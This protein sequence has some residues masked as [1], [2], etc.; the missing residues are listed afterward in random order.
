MTTH[1][2]HLALD[3][4]H[5]LA[6]DVYP[7]L[8]DWFFSSEEFNRWCT[9]R[10]TWRRLHCSG[11]PGC[12]KTTLSALTAQRLRNRFT[13]VP[14]ASV[15]ICTDVRYNETAFVEDFLASICRQLEPSD[16]DAQ[17]DGYIER[18][19]GKRVAI[20]ID[21]I[22][23]VLHE[24]ISSRK[25]TFLVLD[26]VD[27]CGSVLE[28]LLG[29]E[30][31]NLQQR[32]LSVLV[33]SRLPVY[34]KPEIVTCDV[35]PSERLTLFWECDVCHEFIICYPCKEKTDQCEKW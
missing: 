23:E 3:E 1:W 12:G 33:T 21:L 15:F 2:T 30:L 13:D 34:E 18:G 7:R 6:S 8:F 19:H 10:S 28:L 22:R 29:A 14:V 25:R 20:R 35:H 17:L 27:R 31:A 24:R 5:A 26:G 9:G 32:G 11:G 4:S 16:E